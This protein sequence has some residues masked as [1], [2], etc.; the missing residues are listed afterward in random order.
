MQR[1]LPHLRRMTLRA[2]ADP[3]SDAQLLEAFVAERD[4]AAMTSDS[5]CT[6][7]A[8]D[9]SLLLNVLMK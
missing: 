3:L 2:G 6:C 5:G 8:A 1:L 4:Q 7:Q 9:S